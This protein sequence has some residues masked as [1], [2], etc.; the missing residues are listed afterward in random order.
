[1]KLNPQDSSILDR[2]SGEESEIL[3]RAVEWC[4]LSSGSRN[5]PGLEAQ[6]AALELVMAQ[7]PGEVEN[8]PLADSHEVAADGALKAQTHPPALM[9]TVRPQAPVQVVLTGHYD[10]VYPAGTVSPR[11]SR[12]RTG[13]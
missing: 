8:V 2:I 12:G 10:T 4:G 6:R 11:S 9:L 13:R 3:G 7:L 5:L 1:M